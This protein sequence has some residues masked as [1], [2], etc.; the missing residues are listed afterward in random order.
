MQYQRI[1]LLHPV[2]AQGCIGASDVGV[3]PNLRLGIVLTP[4]EQARDHIFGEVR[5][6]LARVE[7]LHHHQD[8]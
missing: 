3:V 8:H 6:H 7:V 1:D 2:F 4:N 5:F